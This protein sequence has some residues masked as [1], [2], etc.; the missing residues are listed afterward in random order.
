MNDDRPTPAELNSLAN[1]IAEE[2]R[3]MAPGIE[4]LKA[5]A[6]AAA[7]E[8]VRKRV[9][10][11]VSESGRVRRNSPCPCGSGRKFKKCCLPEVK[12]P[13]SEKSLPRPAALRAYLRNQ[14]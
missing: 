10:V 8:A 3:P 12:D 2:V 1:Q 4:T 13:E 5:K 14:R 6:R 11:S 9:D 7:A